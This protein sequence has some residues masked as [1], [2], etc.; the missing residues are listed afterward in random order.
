MR[1]MTTW[2]L[3]LIAFVLC[4]PLASGAADDALEPNLKKTPQPNYAGPVP[5]RV[6]GRVVWREQETTLGAAGVSVTDGYSVTKTNAQG[7]RDRRATDGSGLRTSL[8]CGCES[9]FS[10]TLMRY[11]P[12]A[13]RWH[14]SKD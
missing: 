14:L 5:S 6:S 10:S 8:R 11:R 1:P 3:A 7:E 13:S 2:R 9:R 4:T 12:I